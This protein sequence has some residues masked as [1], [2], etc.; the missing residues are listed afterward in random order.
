MLIEWGRL[1]DGCGES[2]TY[3]W[4]V[5]HISTEL[6]IR[7]KYAARESMQ[8][9]TTLVARHV[10]ELGEAG[11]GALVETTL[12]MAMTAW[13]CS[14]P[15]EAMLAA[16]ASVP[17]LGAMRIDFVDVVRRTV[18]VTALGLLARRGEPTPTRPA[19]T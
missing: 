12:M 6:A 5:V 7:H 8:A 13:P 19:T 10:P 3:S 16:Y 2:D 15:S 9:L 1:P 18:E 14:R 17:A 11:A 4:T